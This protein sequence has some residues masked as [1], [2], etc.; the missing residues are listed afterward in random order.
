MLQTDLTGQLM[1]AGVMQ[2]EVR[3][4]SDRVMNYFL[5]AY[6]LAGL[7]FALFYDTWL[8]AIGVGGLSLIAYYSVRLVLPNSSLSQYVLSV[9]LG[10]FMAQ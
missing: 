3:K 6:F 8:I 4:R 1:H 9:V 7:V 5:P 10:I 2:K